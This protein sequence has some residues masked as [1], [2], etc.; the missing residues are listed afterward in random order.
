[1]ADGAA[2][3][4]V[5]DSDDVRE[6]ITVTLRYAGYRVAEA[7]TGEEGLAKAKAERPRLVVL[8][9]LLP[10]IDGWEVMDTLRASAETAGVPVLVLSVLDP[11]PLHRPDAHIVKPFTAAQIEEKV[12]ELA[13]PP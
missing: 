10:G 8:D 3:L 2:V 6:L 4:V 13:G 12:R 9:L 1:M 11:D 5:E 7:E